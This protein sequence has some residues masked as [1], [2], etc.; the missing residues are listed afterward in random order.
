MIKINNEGQN[1]INQKFKNIIIF[2]KN[3]KLIKIKKRFL[4][5]IIL[6]I[7]IS[8]FIRNY[9]FFSS[10]N[11]K[12][13]NI[14]YFK[15][16]Y[17]ILNK[18]YSNEKIKI[19]KLGKIYINECLNGSFI[20]NHHKLHKIKKSVITSIIPVYN[21]E[22]TIKSAIRSIQNQ[23]ITDIE[24]ILVNDFSKDNSLKIIENLQ[25]EDK[26][27]IIINNNRNMGTL[28]S[29]CIGSL[30]SKGE[31]IFALDNDDMFFDED[32]FYFIHKKAKEGN[33][34]IIGFK[35]IY[36]QNY[37][38][39][40]SK[41]RDGYFSHHPNN[42]V[43]YQPKLGI[44]PI[45]INGRYTANDYT[46]WAKCIRTEIYIKAINA[47]GIKKYSSF[48][49]WGED[50]SIIFIIFNIAKS[51]KFIH[52]YGIIHL[53]SFSTST[54]TQPLNN[55]LFGEIFLLNIIFDFSKNNADKNFAANHALYIKRRYNIKNFIK[56]KNILYLKKILK[57][58]I[59]CKYISES[60]KNR[61][62]QNFK[63]IIP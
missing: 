3:I 38:D 62:K 18:N 63:D 11:L 2:K 16:K 50:T 49:S 44:Y 32:I 39:D 29:R 7:I 61:I 60:F 42:L 41:M 40:I 37:N 45:S 17:N 5:I 34:D 27:I 43:L 24:I 59:N 10:K 19:L 25:N 26:R 48:L 8:L 1:F 53:R 15:N 33:F 30:M 21:C 6:F 52:K 47:L 56:D 13:I 35:S 28:Y 4:L 55:V 14:K 58:I 9:C 54:F 57:K 51:F 46:I 22:K 36:I 12:I 31:Y 20:N 23:N